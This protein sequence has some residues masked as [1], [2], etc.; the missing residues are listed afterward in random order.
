MIIWII[1]G[2]YSQHFAELTGLFLIGPYQTPFIQFWYVPVAV[3]LWIT[4]PL[5]SIAK[6]QIKRVGKLILGLILVIPFIYD[7]II[8][9]VNQFHYFHLE[10]ISSS[11]PTT[12][13]GYIF[14]ACI[15]YLLSNTVQSHQ[16]FTKRKLVI[17]S[18][19]FIIMG[20]CVSV[21]FTIHHFQ[22][23]PKLMLVNWYTNIWNVLFSIGVAILLLIIS[24]N[25]LI[26]KTHTVFAWLAKRSM[27][28]FFCHSLILDQ[29]V[30]YTLSVITHMLLWEILSIWL[31]TIVF[32]FIVVWI[33]GYIPV[34]G[35][36]LVK[37]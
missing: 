32:S 3:I 36:I 26:V 28:V 25:T 13:V 5:I 29:V 35:K 6:N 17:I 16:Y 12:F 2:N 7:T 20:L 18:F 19:I 33:I 21:L 30:K 31:M 23:N 27:A 22:V 11:F 8:T 34:V 15:G 9:L 1:Q 4:L 14:L 24:D 10:T 37:D